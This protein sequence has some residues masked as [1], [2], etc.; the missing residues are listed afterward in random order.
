[1]P[2]YNFTGR[3]HYLWEVSANNRFTKY[4][5]IM[6]TLKKGFVYSSESESDSS[7]EDKLP[8][9]NESKHTVNKSSV[10][11]KYDVWSDC[12]NE[13]FVVNQIGT[14]SMKKLPV[15]SQ[16]RKC[17]SYDFTNKQ[18]EVPCD[19]DM[20]EL[21]VT[22]DDESDLFSTEKEVRIPDCD[23]PSTYD[24]RARE[25]IEPNSLLVKKGNFSEVKK[26]KRIPV[27]ERLGKH[28]HFNKCDEHQHK[29]NSFNRVTMKICKTLN[30]PKHH[31]IQSVINVVGETK[32]ME[33]LKMTE[34]VEENGGL[35]T[36][37]GKRRRTP[38]GI[39]FTLLKSDKNISKKQMRSIFSTEKE[40][41]KNKQK[42]NTKKKNMKKKNEKNE[43]HSVNKIDCD[44]T[45][46]NNVEQLDE[47]EDEDLNL[48]F[49]RT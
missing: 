20:V 10:R 13:E 14:V 33:L 27:K 18:L 42:K 3:Y 40:I 39:Y 5:L 23:D 36:Q 1:M 19:S 9:K 21:M 28:K 49:T 15:N 30:E 29:K 37:N 4:A 32:A 47:K 31:L 7:D 12:L 24:V 38:G 44:D 22:Q 48:S 41:F 35:M 26:A 16:N 45:Q 6:S 8:V 11:K 34:E 25:N 43:L 17:E 46:L 2:F